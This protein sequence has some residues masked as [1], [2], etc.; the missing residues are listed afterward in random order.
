M[1]EEDNCLIPS[2]S[3]ERA[4]PAK[5]KKEEPTE[6][7]VVLTAY[8]ALRGALHST[9]SWHAGEQASL[10]YCPTGAGF[11]GQPGMHDFTTAFPAHP[12]DAAYLHRFNNTC[13]TVRLACDTEQ[14]VINETL[15]LR[16]MFQPAWKWML[17]A[18]CFEVASRSV[19]ATMTLTAKMVD[20]KLMD[21]VIQ[22]DAVSVWHQLGLF[23]LDGLIEPLRIAARLSKPTPGNA[24]RRDSTISIADACTSVPKQRFN[25]VDLLTDLPPPTPQNTAKSGSRLVSSNP[26]FASRKEELFVGQQSPGMPVTPTRVNPAMQ[27]SL[28]LGDGTDEPKDMKAVAKSSVVSGPMGTLLDGPVIQMPSRGLNER[29][30]A[31]IFGHGSEHAQAKEFFRPDNARFASSVFKPDDDIPTQSIISTEHKTL[32]DKSRFSSHIFDALSAPDSTAQRGENRSAS[33]Q[34]ANQTRFASHILSPAD[35]LEPVSA[36]KERRQAVHAVEGVL[37]GQTT[38]M[39]PRFPSTATSRSDPNASQITFDY[40]TE[41]KGK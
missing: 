10:T 27:T 8:Y 41:P 15:V 31:D 23:K 13:T 9:A 5:P 28:F 33:M 17:P 7:E 32:A 40:Y 29:I 6:R 4:I 19:T 12:L 37:F 21:L 18:G 36:G 38:P 25:M 16:T 2:R 3:T 35:D 20:S 39:K 14:A 26:A 24:V 11:T 30:Q 1:A 34:A 22:W